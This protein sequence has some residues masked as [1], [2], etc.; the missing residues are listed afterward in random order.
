MMPLRTLLKPL[1]AMLLA[2][3]ACAALAAPQHALTLYDEPPKYPANFKHVDYV[4]PDAPKGGI[5]RKSALGTFDSLNPFINK[6]VP[7]DDIDLTFGTLA[8]QSLDEPFT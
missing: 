1:C 4:N 3:L 8:R 5:F 7:A 6:G 2:S